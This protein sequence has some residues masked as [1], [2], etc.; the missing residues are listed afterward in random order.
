MTRDIGLP[1]AQ[2]IAAFA[3]KQY[4]AAIDWIEPVRDI[5]HRFGGSH[6]QRDLLTLTLIEAALRDNQP[7]RAGHYLSERFVHKPGSGWAQRL[8]DRMRSITSRS[9]IGR[10]AA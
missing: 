4:S 7:A 8:A 2:G 10:I 1:L 6:A 9:P 5:A 3:R